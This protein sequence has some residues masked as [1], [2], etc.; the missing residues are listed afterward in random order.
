MAHSLMSAKA[1]PICTFKQ[2]SVVGPLWTRQT[3]R[4]R[5]CKMASCSKDLQRQLASFSSAPI[6]RNIVQ[7]P[8]APRCLMVT[9]APDGLQKILKDYYEN[10]ANP[11]LYWRGPWRLLRC[12][13]LASLKSS[14]LP[15]FCLSFERNTSISM[16]LLVG[17]D[18][19]PIEEL[20]CE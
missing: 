5:H 1:C 12:T 3:V 2:S 18:E 16:C 4:L 9:L 20:P 17:D 8:R 7:A 10:T 6:A 11:D 15:F 14:S 13:A 19:K